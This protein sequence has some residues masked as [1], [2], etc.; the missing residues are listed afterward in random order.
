M[1]KG[2]GNPRNTGESEKKVERHLRD[3]MKSIGGKAD[4]WECPSSVGKP[5]RVCEF[6]HGLVVFAEL[7]SEGKKPSSPQQR[8][9]QRMRDRGQAVVVL[10]TTNKVNEFISTYRE[11]DREINVQKCVE[12][13][14]VRSG[15]KG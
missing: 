5:D 2:L 10:D 11:I 7:K 8:E 14:L 1:L 9:H 12:E 3:K 15:H 4:K 6:P 13:S